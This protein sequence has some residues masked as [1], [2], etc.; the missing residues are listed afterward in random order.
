MTITDAAGRAVFSLDA[1]GGATRAG[2]VFLNAGRYTVRFTR[3]RGQWGP[4]TS[5]LF[6]LSGLSLSDSLGP[7]LRDA[8]RDPV[9]PSAAAAMPAPSFFWLPFGPADLPSGGTASAA[10]ARNVGAAAASDLL[11]GTTGPGLVGSAG[12]IQAPRLQFGTD[13]PPPISAGS[14]PDGP[15]PAAPLAGAGSRNVDDMGPPEP[16]VASP[17]EQAPGG[18]TPAATTSVGAADDNSPLPHRGQADCRQAGGVGGPAAEDRA[19]AEMAGPPWKGPLSFALTLA[20]LMLAGRGDF[21]AR[22]LRRLAAVLAGP[23]SAGRSEHEPRNRRP[24]VGTR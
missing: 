21:V 22:G 3:D 6:K 7:Q 9:A 17:R 23:G 20:A 12:S 2:D 16:L 1:G 13:A 10:A 4:W 11:S 8:T 19:L 14:N 24:P 18:G 15:R 5:V